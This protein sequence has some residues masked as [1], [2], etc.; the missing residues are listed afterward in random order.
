M[1]G[2]IFR[3]TTLR[4]ASYLG[5]DARKLAARL[6]GA[7]G[8]MHTIIDGYILRAQGDGQK[9]IVTV[10]DT[11]VVFVMD[12]GL[13]NIASS[14]G[15]T[16]FVYYTMGMQ[17]PCASADL[18]LLNT[19]QGVVPTATP[20]VDAS[21][22]AR[23]NDQ[24]E[25]RWQIGFKTGP[26]VLSPQS[27]IIELTWSWRHSTVRP[28]AFV[29]AT[30]QY[31]IGSYGIGRHYL[32]CRSSVSKSTAPFLY[33]ATYA[34]YAYTLEPPPPPLDAY[35]SAYVYDQ[36][37]TNAPWS[38]EFDAG[39]G[40]V[41]CAYKKV[42]NLITGG[43]VVDRVAYGPEG[44]MGATLAF[45]RYDD[46][47]SS[48]VTTPWHTTEVV[49]DF[50]AELPVLSIGSVSNEFSPGLVG[51]EAAGAE[52]RKFLFAYQQAEG[53]A[54]MDLA[55]RL[56]QDTTWYNVVRTY[57]YTTGA[58]M[59]EVRELVGAL[60][61]DGLLVS[62]S[63][64]PHLK[65]IAPIGEKMLFAYSQKFGGAGS[66]LYLVDGTGFAAATHLSLGPDWWGF[67]TSRRP[68]STISSFA[69]M[70]REYTNAVVCAEDHIA[71]LAYTAM[72]YPSLTGWKMAVKVVKVSTGALVM[73]GPDLFVDAELAMGYLDCVD[74]GVVDTGTGLFTINPV[75][76]VTLIQKD[77]AASDRID[78]FSRGQTVLSWTGVYFTHDWGLTMNK[79]FS[80]PTMK[81]FFGGWETLKAKHGRSSI[82]WP[83]KAPK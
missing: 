16:S 37:I 62:G 4:A 39:G 68:N 2:V 18:V 69:Y 34:E 46:S 47:G 17:V 33:L 35:D 80:T 15:G 13:N 55:S 1:A 26:D 78:Y 14:E 57:N 58:V 65:F 75:F 29:S 28:H 76:A 61:G 79:L 9:V 20:P 12:A 71:L 74:A 8:V 67:V 44:T 49:D 11:S 60:D 70:T 72:T 40:V 24:E 59:S 5:K 7:K 43:L 50:A 25:N 83:S 56:D 81:M 27:S 66:G 64:I 22:A 51:V 30:F 19:Q 63:A 3:P 82:R 36:E 52:A 77:Y 23:W 42:A 38:Y 54:S 53:R 41:G 6:P 73:T 10:L 48:L 31:G 32:L 21:P 45:T